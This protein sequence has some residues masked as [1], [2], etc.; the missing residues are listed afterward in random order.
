MPTTHVA[1]DFSTIRKHMRRIKVERAVAEAGLTTGTIP[2]EILLSAGFSAEEIATL[3]NQKTLPLNQTD[4][5][6]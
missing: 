4:L 2:N 6:G 3:G 5:L 1:D